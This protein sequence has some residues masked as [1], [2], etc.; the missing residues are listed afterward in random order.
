MDDEL[1]RRR[2]LALAGAGTGLAIAGCVG[3]ADDGGAD[4]TAT[5]DPP[6]TTTEQETTQTTET[7]QKP[8]MS[9]VFHFAS[10]TAE[11]KHAIANVSNLLGDDSV[12]TDTVALVANGAGIRLVSTNESEHVEDLESLLGKGVDVYA[13]RNSMDAF[14]IDESDLVEGVEPVPSGVGKLTTLQA[15]EGF[16]YIE[17]P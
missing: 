11:Q 17:T 5:T 13:C 16:A 6:D 9:T 15:R 7:T 10:G 14:G 1:R 4:P 3:G 12:E 8:D 2:F